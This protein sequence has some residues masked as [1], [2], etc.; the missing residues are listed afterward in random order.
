MI[1][2]FP[3][4]KVTGF[5]ADMTRTIC[6]GTA[7]RELESMFTTV[8]LAQQKALGM[9]APNVS[10]RSIHEAVV[11]FFEANGYKTSGK[12]SEFKFAEGFVHSL[13]HRVSTIIHDTPILSFAKRRGS[14]SRRC[15]H[16]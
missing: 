7:P 15:D 8:H 2:I 1:D 16:H 12:G 13:G 4:S 3:Q 9:I 10:T 14:S 11:S 5:F 6:L